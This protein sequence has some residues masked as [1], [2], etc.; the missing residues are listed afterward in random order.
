MG[1]QRPVVLL[2]EII[3]QFVAMAGNWAVSYV[4]RFTINNPVAGLMQGRSALIAESAVFV[5]NRGYFS[6]SS[7]PA[8]FEL[9]GYLRIVALIERP[10]V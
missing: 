6:E 9:P 7:L 4:S 5:F 8:E 3:G 2:P 1:S 10:V